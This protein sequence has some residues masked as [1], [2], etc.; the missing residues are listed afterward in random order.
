MAA[1]LK[2]NVAGRIIL[3]QEDRFRMVDD[4]GAGY[5]FSLFRKTRTTAADLERWHRQN[6][7]V[8]VEYAGG[9]ESRHR[10]GAQG[11]AADGD[12]NGGGE[13]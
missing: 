3:V 8:L 7:Q 12:V 1:N 5:L 13:Q 4:T 10:H 2:R 11:R 6:V 9:I